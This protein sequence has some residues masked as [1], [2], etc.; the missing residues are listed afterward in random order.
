MDF[1]KLFIDKSL[2]PSE[3]TTVLSNWLILN[4]DSLNELIDFAR[5]AKD[6][7]KASCIE[8]IEY[9]TKTKPGSASSECLKFVSETLSSKAPRVKWESA[10]VIGN[11]AHLYPDQLDV[12][13]NNLLVNSE[14]SG[15][16]VRWSTAFAFSQIIKMKMPFNNDLIPAIESICIREEKNSIKKI[17]LEAIKKLKV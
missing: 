11:I 15:T 14:H 8:A 5:L 6:P 17:Y 12:A 1:N 3:K 9:A 13:I 2:K 4:T 16:V 7:I 10:R